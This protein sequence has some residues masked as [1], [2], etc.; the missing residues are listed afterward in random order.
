MLRAVEIYKMLPSGD[1]WAQWSSLWL[2]LSERC[3]TTWTP[4]GTA[5]R[6]R[7]ATWYS[8]V[9]GLNFFWPGRWYALHVKY[10]SDG[11]FEGCYCDV[12]TP[13]PKLTPDANEVRYTDLYIDVVVDRYRQ[14]TTKDEEVFDWAMQR[15][16]TLVELRDQTYHARDD[17]VRHARDWS[18][19][20]AAI[21]WQL[22]RTDWADLDPT[23]GAFVAACAAQWRAEDWR[24]ES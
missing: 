14:V 9:W 5:M 17:L 4:I 10:A 19:P 13:N 20:F 8:E 16:P 24:G 11:H 23:S 12:V 22:N 3:V 2:P 6:W 7:P 18:G 1:Q 21:P 15:R